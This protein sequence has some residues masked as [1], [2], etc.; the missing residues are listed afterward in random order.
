[1]LKGSIS[2]ILGPMFCGKSSEISRRLKRDSIAGRRF[3]IIKPVIDNRYGEDIY[4]DRDSSFE[5]KA[6]N[7]PCQSPTES[8]LNRIKVELF[9]VEVVAIDE[10]QFF[11]EWI[12]NFV[13]E[14][15]TAGKKVYIGGLDTDYKAE[16]F[17]FMG[18]L[19]C[20]ANEVMKLQAVCVLCGEDAFRTQ[21][22]INNKPAPLGENVVIGDKELSP[23]DIHYQARC[24]NHYISPYT[25]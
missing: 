23:E 3:A 15:R 10:A 13:K 20:I 1:M 16:P 2:V 25:I 14:L 11:E 24:D 22:L 21:R 6:F 9:N 5:C 18:S 17:G 7:M 4:R 12:V 8:E 19:C